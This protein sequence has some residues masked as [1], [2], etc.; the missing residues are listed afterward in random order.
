MHANP[1]YSVGELAA[2]KGAKYPRVRRAYF[3]PDHL[4]LVAHEMMQPSIAVAMV[5][6][7]KTGRESNRM[8]PVG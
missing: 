3:P 4:C 1:R 5:R 8:K 7:S 2:M 6:V